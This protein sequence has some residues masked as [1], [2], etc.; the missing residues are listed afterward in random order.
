MS[1]VCSRQVLQQEGK[2]IHK[3]DFPNVEDVAAAVDSNL[4]VFMKVMSHAVEL[5][6]DTLK[7]IERA[8]AAL[9][10]TVEDPVALQAELD[11]AVSRFKLNL[12]T[13]YTGLP[14][15]I[16]KYFHKYLHKTYPP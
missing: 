11:E 1:G 14:K 4:G 8:P 15:P 2:G 13:D 6:S 5:G 3:Q 16:V 9:A 12:F 7:V 10:D